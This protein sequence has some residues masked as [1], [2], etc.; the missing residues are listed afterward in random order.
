M[1]KI[2]TINLV[3]VAAT[4]GLFLFRWES[5]SAKLLLVQNNG[6]PMLQAKHVEELERIINV[7]DSSSEYLI[8]S[9][10]SAEAAEYLASVNKNLAVAAEARVREVIAEAK[11]AAS[12]FTQRLADADK[13]LAE[14]E[15]KLYAAENKLIDTETK[16]EA[17]N[18]AAGA[19][20]KKLADSEAKLKVAGVAAKEAV[21][22]LDHIQKDLAAGDVAV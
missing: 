22:A 21:E 1:T 7:V 6:P 13:K 20:E 9:H 18:A 5:I 14:T 16:L 10:T 19:I 2:K 3:L 12:Q 15:D 11:E 8:D 17:A 4:L